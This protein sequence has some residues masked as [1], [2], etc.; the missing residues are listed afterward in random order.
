MI[1]DKELLPTGC[2]QVS[3]SVVYP[4]SW[5]N[6]IYKGWAIFQ[7]LKQFL[8]VVDVTGL[9]SSFLK[10]SKNSISFGESEENPGFGLFYKAWTLGSADCCCLLEMK[11]RMIQMCLLVVLL[12]APHLGEVMSVFLTAPG[13]CYSAWEGWIG[14]SWI[15]RLTFS[16]QNYFC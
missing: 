1:W 14:N 2:L 16:A 15:V 6:L 12:S 9:Q 7:F 4:Q 5:L 11:W 3:L 8:D 10:D 13:L